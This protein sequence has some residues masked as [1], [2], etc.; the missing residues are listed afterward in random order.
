MNIN[1]M[2][3]ITVIQK[4]KSLVIVQLDGRTVSLPNGSQRDATVTVE[5]GIITGPADLLEKI[6]DGTISVVDW[7]GHRIE[8]MEAEETEVE[9]APPAKV[10]PPTAAEAKAKEAPSAAPATKEAPKAKP[11]VKVVQHT[12]TGNLLEQP[13][14]VQE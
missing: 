13:K 8:G 11:P 9:E 4:G 3:R 12:N 6:Q 7:H 14:E 2:P 5:D 10:V 1:N